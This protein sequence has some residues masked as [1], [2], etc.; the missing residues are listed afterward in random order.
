MCGIAGAYSLGGFART[1]PIVRNIVTTQHR[2]GPDHQAIESIRGAQTHVVVGHN[3]LSIIDLTPLANQP[4]WDNGHRYCLVYNG[5]IYNYLELKAELSALGH[6][7]FSRSD[8]EVILEAFK[9][10]GLD[11]LGRF[12]GMFAFALYDSED[13]MMWLVRDRF[14]V[15][16]LFYYSNEDT[17]FFASTGTA[18]AECERLEPNLDYVARGLVYNIYEDDTEIS[19]YQGL[20]SL[21]P[22]HCLQLRP[23]PSGKPAVRLHSYYDL[24]SRVRRLREAVVDQSPSELTRMV[25]ERLTDAVAI[26]LRSDVPMGIS[27][28]GGLDSATLAGLLAQRHDD[29][30]GFTFGSAEEPAS[31]GPVVEAMSK[32][33]PMGIHFVWPRP[34][35]FIDAFWEALEAQDAPFPGPSIVAQYLVFKAAS[36]HGVKVLLGGQG[37][38][39]LFMGYRKFQLF[40][41]LELARRKRYLDAIEAAVGLFSV[42]LTEYTK[43]LDYVGHLERYRGGRR[44]TGPLRLPAPSPVA[45]GYDP[46]E[47]LWE[48][49]LQDVTRYS[50]PTLLRYE[51]RN[52]MGNSV[53]SRLPF[54]DYRL[55]ELALALP[56]ALK[57]RRGYG[58]WIVRQAAT[59]MVLDRIR[60]AR[61]KRPFDVHLRRWIE[62]GLGESV[63]VRL[64]GNASRLQGFLAPGANIN[65]AWADAQL[66]G[67]PAALAEAVALIW[68]GDRVQ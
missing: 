65:E 12:N 34:A 24:E 46:A 4:M 49:Q 32:R 19:P 7:F 31:E 38:D 37:G 41:F 66:V 53:E 58:K 1:E 56:T 43:I 54:L 8:S 10:W 9:E 13:E 16:P 5:E 33:S 67:R 36:T 3:R 59:G 61:Y 27:L 6:R 68:L 25:T 47:P 14:G 18:I 2:R 35:E 55:V 60:L 15:K 22:G 28:S 21:R 45:M 62:Q 39:E 50:L 23:T 20:K 52:S 44:Q 57:I 17:V 40:H 26:R 63:R 29:I 64:H 11:A 42:L 51:D 48:R 30:T